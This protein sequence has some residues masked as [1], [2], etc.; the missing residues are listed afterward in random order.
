MQDQTSLGKI[1]DSQDKL[2]PFGFLLHGYK[3]GF[4]RR[5]IWLEVSRFTKNREL[6]GNST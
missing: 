1:I 6:F 3:D 4:S 2:K 5:L